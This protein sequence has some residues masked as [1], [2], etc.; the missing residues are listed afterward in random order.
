LVYNILKIRTGFFTRIK[1]CKDEII[2]QEA[3][4]QKGKKAKQSN[5]VE[6]TSLTSLPLLVR[7]IHQHYRENDYIIKETFKALLQD[8]DHLNILINKGQFQFFKQFINYETFKAMLISEGKEDQISEA[9]GRMSHE[10][11]NQVNLVMYQF[12]NEIQFK[13]VKHSSIF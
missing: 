1:V 7:T 13:Q 2:K 3:A 12:Y 11:L 8:Q 4:A 9:R 6:D 5:V 10:F